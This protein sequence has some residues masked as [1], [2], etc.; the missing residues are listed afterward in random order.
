M[1]NSE[2]LVFTA[3]MTTEEAAEALGRRPDTLRKWHSFKR[4][5]IEPVLIHG[6]LAWR[7]AD[8]QAMLR[9]EHPGRKTGRKPKQPGAGPAQAVA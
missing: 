1:M 7:V 4:G 8:V 6:R 2:I 5:P 3:M 9:G